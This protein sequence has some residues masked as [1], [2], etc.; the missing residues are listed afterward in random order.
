M[1]SISPTG[2]QDFMLAQPDV[3]APAQ[4]PKHARPRGSSFEGLSSVPPR[5][6]ASRG[7][8]AQ[9][10]SVAI[11]KAATALQIEE[12]YLRMVRE[13]A[14][15]MIQLCI[16]D[17]SNA[18]AAYL[19][20]PED[21]TR[22]VDHGGQLLGPLRKVAEAVKIVR[23]KGAH[24]GMGTL[25]VIRKAKDEASERA[26]G[27]PDAP[28]LPGQRE[29]GPLSLFNQ[30]LT[31]FG[32]GYRSVLDVIENMSEVRVLL[33]PYVEMHDGKATLIRS[34]SDL[35]RLE[36]I[37]VKLDENM[38][39]TYAAFDKLFDCIGRNM[40]ELRSARI[41]GNPVDL[42]ASW[43]QTLDVAVSTHLSD[44][45]VTQGLVNLVH[46][47]LLHARLEHFQHGF[48]ELWREMQKDAPFGADHRM[49]NQEEA[50]RLSDLLQ[51][52]NHVGSQ[53]DD[54]ARRMDEGHRWIEGLRGKHGVDENTVLLQHC[55]LLDMSTRIDIDAIGLFDCTRDFGSAFDLTAGT[56]DPAALDA[57]KEV[58]RDMK[59]RIVALQRNVVHCITAFPNGN[60]D[61]YLGKD[62]V[63]RETVLNAVAQHCDAIETD[64]A[65]LRN[66]VND[67]NI[68]IVNADDVKHVYDR[69][70]AGVSRIRRDLQWNI[71]VA[72]GMKKLVMER[73]AGRVPTL[74]FPREPDDDTVRKY[75]SEHLIDLEMPVAEA[76]TVPHIDWDDAPAAR[77]AAAGVR[78][79]MTKRRRKAR[80]DNN[81][82]LQERKKT[83]ERDLAARLV[84]AKESLAVL[85]AQAFDVDGV[86]GHA[87]AL[88]AHARKETESS[89]LHLLSG[90]GVYGKFMHAVNALDAERKR[91]LNQIVQIDRLV[92]TLIDLEPDGGAT[93]NA[94][95]DRKV[96]TQHVERLSNEIDALRNEAVRE[97]KRRNLKQFAQSPSRE[98]FLWL[99]KH[100]VA[101]LVSV[102]KTVD[103]QQLSGIAPNGVA[104]T[105]DDFFDEYVI[106]LR[107][108][109]EITYFDSDANEP[110][111]A[112]VTFVPLHVHYRSADAKRPEAC[113]F[114]NEPQRMV[115]GR[116]AYRSDDSVA[117]MAGVLATVIKMAA[118][119]R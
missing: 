66:S 7:D 15:L 34:L 60:A 93:S 102:R 100:D 36:K 116:G 65:W 39:H 17:C 78:S 80:A 10:T 72:E 26:T 25:E 5:T 75:V 92:D 37:A 110:R 62:E 3:D 19:K 32:D 85:C 84:A 91:V 23:G 97:Q 115:A 28:R 35:D 8:V 104:R 20:T 63:L 89:G 54:F 16:R 27:G 22:I 45:S 114:K 43:K 48:D 11:P 113:H 101:S 73:L 76:V 71:A 111:T 58:S 68:G 4:S 29:R 109:Q 21:A 95:P 24:L 105:H 41:R 49:I 86:R 31:A 96:L 46:E 51:G 42:E 59:N 12:A 108:P 118:P 69:L 112:N 99:R 83:E 47:T 64:L 57:F 44:L 77:P 1:S 9:R 70:Q 67:R 82:I 88:A 117:L 13:K 107:D 81:R 98:R 56:H 6:S 53:Y 119:A 38:T 52:S 90:N 103:R 18:Q 14:P 30:E 61:V 74:A 94:L 87:E 50:R 33:E 79:G 55:G 2:H 106:T 40:P